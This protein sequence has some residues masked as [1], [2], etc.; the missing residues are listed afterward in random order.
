MIPQITI[1]V[2]AIAPAEMAAPPMA[3]LGG[4][5]PKMPRTLSQ[6]HSI[7]SPTV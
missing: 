3:P 5:V 6:I 2:H 7:Q 4:L 1:M